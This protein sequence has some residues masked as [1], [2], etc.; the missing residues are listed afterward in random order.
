MTSDPIATGSMI[1]LPD[2]AEIPCPTC[3]GS[4]TV[5][6]G[7]PKKMTPRE[8][9]VLKYRLGLFGTRRHT[10][11]EIGAMLG[12]RREYVRQME[13]KAMRRLRGAVRHRRD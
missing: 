9:F 7:L 8:R 3:G 2:I 13:C 5:V 11:A 10:Y 4:G 6:R 12:F 1:D